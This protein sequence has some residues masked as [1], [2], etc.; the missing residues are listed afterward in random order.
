MMRRLLGGPFEMLNVL[1][2]A[3]FFAIAGALTFLSAPNWLAK[4]S[5]TSP[6]LAAQQFH[7]VAAL[8]GRHGWWIAAA[9]FLGA[10]V[11]PVA[12]GDGKKLVAWIRV[13]CAAAALVIVAMQWGFE[14]GGLISE[15]ASSKSV[16]WR[17]DKS[18][19]PWNALLV[20]TGM[21]LCLGAFQITG[22]AAKKAKSAS[23][24]K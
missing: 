9:A 7:D 18:P 23:P 10:A 20:A 3:T 24:E 1:G 19:T 2:T 13:G 11:A 4:I 5:R 14:S 16:P 12:R 21:N 15:S 22:G 17:S 6:D 8:I